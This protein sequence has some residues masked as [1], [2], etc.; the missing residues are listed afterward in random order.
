MRISANERVGEAPNA[1]QTDSGEDERVRADLAERDRRDRERK[2][3][4]LAVP[5]GAHVIDTTGR[6]LDSIVKEALS[7]VNRVSKR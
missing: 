7:L 1:G 5:E 4:P 3:S 6:N 2:H